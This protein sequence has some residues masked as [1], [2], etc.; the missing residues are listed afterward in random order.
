MNPKEWQKKGTHF[1]YKNYQIF[2]REE[3]SGEPLLL[4]H[5]FPTASWDWVKIWDK[6][7]ERFQVLAP[8]MIGFGFSEKPKFYNYSITDQAELHEQFIEEKGIKS[9]HV[10][11]HDYGNSV[12][13]ELMARQLDGSLS[14]K[15]KSVVFLNGGLFPEMHRPKLIQK[16]LLSPIGKFLHPFL[17]R[18]SLQRNFN[19]IFGKESQPTEE[20]IDGF[21]ELI[22]HNDG[23]KI[24]YKLI[25]YITDRRENRTRWVNALKNFNVPIRLIDGPEDPISGRHL[26]EYYLKEMPNPD[27]IILDGI[28]HYPQTEAPEKVLRYAFEFWD[29]IQ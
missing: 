18:S 13:Q 25:G 10:L 15:I 7:T 17:G 1:K 19:D 16:L 9:L 29:K 26:A 5:G 6:L 8:D 28:G 20:E 14:F 4:I 21:W 24:F 11:A 23:K 22:Q 2:Y 27:V 3:G 12:A